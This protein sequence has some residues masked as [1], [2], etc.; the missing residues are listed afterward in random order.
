MHML[1]RSSKITVAHVSTTSY[2]DA[3]T[4]C[5]MVSDVSELLKALRIDLTLVLELNRTIKLRAQRAC[6]ANVCRMPGDHLIGV[7]AVVF[8]LVRR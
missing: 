2:A 7:E 5:D 6:N 3:P 1:R 4:F 8:T